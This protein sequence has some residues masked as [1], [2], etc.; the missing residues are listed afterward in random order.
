MHYRSDRRDRH[1]YRVALRRDVQK[2]MHS[3]G[4]SQ[5]WVNDDENRVRHYRTWRDRYTGT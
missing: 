5:A 1:D 2:G 4:F 3:R